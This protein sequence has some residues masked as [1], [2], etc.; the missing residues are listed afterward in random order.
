M[1]MQFFKLLILSF[2]MQLVFISH[3]GAQQSAPL[4]AEYQQLQTDTARLGFL[5]KAIADS[6]DEGQ[7]EPVLS[8]S[9]LGLTIAEKNK[10]DS[11]KGIFYFDIA[12][13]YTYKYNKYDSA[14]FYYKKVPAYFPDLNRRYNIFSIREIM[15]R[16]ADLG[17]K[18]SSFV[19]LG[20][21]TAFIDT[22]VAGNPKRVTLSQN[23]ATIYQWF[24]MYK[25]AIH[26][27]QVAI[28]G[29]RLN[30]NFKGLGLALANLGLLYNEMEDNGKAIQYSKEALEYLA[31][32]KMPYMQTAANIASYYFDSSRYDSAA[33]YLTISN[34]IVEKINDNEQKVVNNNILAGILIAKKK[35]DV[36]NDILNNNLKALSGNDDKSNLCKTLLVFA[37]LDTSRKQYDV[38]KKHLG[39]MLDISRKNDYKIMSV[40]ALQN[41]YLVNSAT[42]DYKAAYK[43]QLE[44]MQLKDSMAND[45]AKS[46]LNDL[47]ISYKSLQ[48]DQQIALLK[49]DNDIK[50]LQLKESNR[51]RIIYILLIVFLAAFFALL[52][53]QRNRRN[54]IETA[55]IKAELQTQ[56]LRSQMNPHFIFN[57]LNSIENFIM[58][59][60]KRQASDYL[61]KFS[62]LIRTILDSSRN[63]VV[64]IAKDME[65]LKLYVELEQLRFNNKFSFTVHI[66]P[67][68]AGGDYL[69]PSLLVQPF[70][71]NAIV[72]GMAHSEDEGLNLSVTASLEGDKIKYTITDNGIGREK[73]KVYNMQ[74]K[75]YHKS[76]GLKITEERINIFNEQDK[77]ESIHIVD[78]YD[79]NKKPGG[80]KVEITL[81][82]I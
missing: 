32:V 65:A 36:A 37:S 5:M 53:Y 27:F 56:V 59:N 78:L 42:G 34:N 54:K 40:L 19:Y 67:A 26:Y 61:N 58:Q 21:L 70:V 74:N 39:N 2:A 64:P 31:D 60:D 66:D 73:A 76:V 8:W 44:Y 22:M 55:K 75:P 71:E 24:G 17:N 7:L 81:K 9:R 46:D 41:L 43:Y 20:K 14:I 35:Y 28:N 38:A 48:Q 50:G 30:K 72:H 16:Y 10:V 23:I 45:K 4:P 1:R 57:C 77:K 3:G 62:Q 25:T 29:D 12:K 79:E 13:A 68:L 52:Y 63:E 80:T 51:V 33:K 82:A 6:L 15:D 69:V 18:D 49:K 47:E 11:M